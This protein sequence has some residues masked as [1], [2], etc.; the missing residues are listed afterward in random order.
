MKAIVQSEYGS[1]DVLRLEEIGLPT[2]RDG[3]VF[4]RVMQVP[5]EKYADL[6]RPPM[7]SLPGRGL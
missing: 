2:A 7:S 3:E 1:A 6:E 5:N 4:V